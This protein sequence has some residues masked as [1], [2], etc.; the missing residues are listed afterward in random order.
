M[1][2][3]QSDD[4]AAWIRRRA[5][6][7]FAH[8]SAAQFDKAYGTPENADCVARFLDDSAVSTVVFSDKLVAS[9]ALT[10]RG[11]SERRGGKWLAV[12]KVAR[13]GEPLDAKRLDEQLLVHEVP[14]SLGPMGQ[15][16]RT[17]HDVLLPL[18]G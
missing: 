11:A 10:Q 16:D 8:L 15:L 12:V 6:T 18:L 14:A 2:T 17:S 13:D 9:H 3:D 5:E 1:S 4:R 7:T